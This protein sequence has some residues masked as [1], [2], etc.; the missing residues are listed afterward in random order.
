MMKRPQRFLIVGKWSPRWLMQMDDV[1]WQNKHL[2]TV[3]NT[4][5]TWSKRDGPYR[6]T[7]VTHLKIWYWRGKGRER[8][9][10][11]QVTSIRVSQEGE[12]DEAG[13]TKP[14][15]KEDTARSFNASLLRWKRN[16][17]ISHRNNVCVHQN[18]EDLSL[19]LAR[20]LLLEEQ[21][22]KI[23]TMTMKFSANSGA[24]AGKSLP[25]RFQSC[26]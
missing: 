7:Q 8:G 25:K 26:R 19:P 23:A 16:K 5:E 17:R 12:E 21:R 22:C 20:C 6:N 18:N 10:D 4:S 13:M 9:E 11:E 3:E 24:I 15:R 2:F 1:Y 14:D